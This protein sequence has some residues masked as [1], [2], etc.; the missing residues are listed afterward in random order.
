M[1]ESAIRAAVGAARQWTPESPDLTGGLGCCGLCLQRYRTLVLNGPLQDLPHGIV[2]AAV[3]EVDALIRARS[4]AGPE[5]VGG[6]LV[7]ALEEFGAASGCFTELRHRD[8]EP[9]IERYLA[10]TREDEFPL[11]SP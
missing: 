7:I 3:A 8:I 6:L 9:A 2:H 1:F 10:R 11:P 4:G 5:A